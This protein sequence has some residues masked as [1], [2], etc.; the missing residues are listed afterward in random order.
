MISTFFVKAFTVDTKYDIYFV[1]HGFC[2][3]TSLFNYLRL[4]TVG[5]RILI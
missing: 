1:I 2:N 3:A 4:F 5:N